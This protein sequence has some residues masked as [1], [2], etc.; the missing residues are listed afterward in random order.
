ML[1]RAGCPLYSYVHPV[2]LASCQFQ[3]PGGQDAHSTAILTQLRTPIVVIVVA[4]IVDKI[5]YKCFTPYPRYFELLI[6]PF[7]GIPVLL[8]D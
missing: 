7:P 6:T 3:F 8:S 5:I 4:I 2:E 1:G